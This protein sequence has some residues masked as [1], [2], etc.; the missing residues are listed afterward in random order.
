MIIQAKSPYQ[1]IPLGYAGENISRTVVFDISHWVEQ[2]GEG[3]V[4]L[5]AKR[6]G[7]DGPYPAVTYREENQILWPVREEDLYSGGYGEA[8][9]SYTVGGEV[10]AR[11][12][13]YRT[14][15]RSSIEDGKPADNPEKS[16]V[17]AV[18]EAVAQVE[19]SASE[20]A[21]S[22]G[23]AKES[24]E[25]AAASAESAQESAQS[26]G[27]AAQYAESAQK[28]ETAAS[29]SAQS[30]A[31]SEAVASQSATKAAS[32][33]DAAASDAAKAQASEAAAAESANKA[34]ESASTVAAGVTAAAESATAAAADAAKAQ[35]AAEAA[36]RSATSTADSAALAAESA[37]AAQTAQEAAKGYASTAEEAKQ[38]AESARAA[39]EAASQSATNGASSAENAANAAAE[40]L[41]DVQGIVDNLGG[42]SE[43]IAIKETATGEV[44]SVSDSA[45]YRLLGLKLYG[46]SVQD[47]VP[48]PEAPVEIKSTGN[49][50]SIQITILG[51]N[52]LPPARDSV[53]NVFIPSGTTLYLKTKDGAPSNGG[54][55][56]LKATSGEDIWFS[57]ESGE[58]S[59]TTALKK[60]VVRFYNY[61]QTG[62]EFSLQFTDAPFIAYV[63]PQT[64]TLETPDGLSGIPVESG[65]NYTD[66]EGQQ[67]ICDEVDFASGKKIQRVGVINSYN[68]ESVGEVY[69]SSTGQLTA[70]AKVLYQ[71][72][73]PVTEEIPSDTLD[74]YAA[75]TA[76]KP[77]TNIMSDNEPAAEISAHYIAD[78]KAY[79]D[80]QF[81]ALANLQKQMDALIGA[82]SE[83]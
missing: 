35:A 37:S 17:A 71:L 74:A 43:A 40:T 26:A 4:L 32:D 75:L 7:D 39:A 33:A 38:A 76:Y 28:S 79:I 3:S 36:E 58:A 42:L 73:T 78:T 14:T 65:G 9:L 47:G 81:E 54:N 16:W 30:A 19:S 63:Q 57:I 60:D 21:A 50:G 66:A 20:A 70:G 68:S 59:S 18:T 1:P 82:E 49:G 22:A 15:T 46:Q 23:E 6:P 29:E 10:V 52:I 34:A 13:V 45:D 5:L 12:P 77:V 64:L 80:R 51:A 55:I 11:S 24:A 72:D 48:T 31:Q 61:L 83:A 67:W 44:I 62:A 27:Q 69:M 53:A 8:Q 2:Y 56:L 25:G 41:K